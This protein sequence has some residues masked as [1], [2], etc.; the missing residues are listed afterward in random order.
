M[1]RPVLV[2]CEVCQSEGRLLTSNGGPDDV[3]NGPC[4][5][6][7]ATGL[8]LVESEA[9]TLDDLTELAPHQHEWRLT[10]KIAVHVDW[11]TKTQGR[12]ECVARYVRCEC[13]QVGYRR[14]GSEVVYTWATEDAEDDGR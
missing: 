10:G 4:P 5:A 6:C 3:D 1:T 7:D 2:L 12:R 9:I 13:G 14:H 8:A 11:P